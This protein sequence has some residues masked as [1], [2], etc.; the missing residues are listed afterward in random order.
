LAVSIELPPPIATRLSKPPSAR[1]R[2]PVS[3]IAVV[4]SGTV[5]ENTDQRIRAPSSN[6]VA[7]S[8][9]PQPAI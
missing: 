1:I 2:V 6:P 9:I 8:R 7:R 5:S 3:T 4:G